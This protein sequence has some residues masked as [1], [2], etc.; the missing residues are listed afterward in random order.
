MW[1]Y[2]YLKSRDYLGSQVG[3]TINSNDSHQT[4]LGGFLSLLLSILY[5]YFFV[6]FS[7]DMIYKN[8]PVGYDQ[9]KLNDLKN[10]HLDI[11][12]KHLPA[13]K[14]SNWFGTPYNISEYFFEIFEL[15]NW[16]LDNTTIIK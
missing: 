5:L 14:M 7:D 10:R 2:T 8:N 12:D 9:M 13:Y 1:I 4:V 11:S 16:K 3:F 6:L 15:H